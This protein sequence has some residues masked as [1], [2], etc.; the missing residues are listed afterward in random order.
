MSEAVKY[1]IR[2]ATIEDVEFLSE[3]L[4]PMDLVEID[5]TTGRS[6]Y[7]VLKS[8]L[9][10]SDN[11]MVGTADGVPICIYGV[12]KP[13]HLSDSGVIWMLGTDDVEKHFMKFGRECKNEVKRMVSNL[14]MVENYCHAD[15]KKTIV[16]LKWLGFKFEDPAPYGRKGEMFRRFY[17]GEDN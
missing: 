5:A 17:L 4:K 14:R 2:L 6:P 9:E 15:N 3:R 11:C 8:G 16:W 13:S 10:G 7:Q 1:D 12:R